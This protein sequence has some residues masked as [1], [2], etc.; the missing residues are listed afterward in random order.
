MQNSGKKLGQYFLFNQKKIRKIV[1]ALDL[2]PGDV[3]IEIGP[4]HG[5]LTREIIKELKSVAANEW[6]FILIEK[7]KKLVLE[8]QRKFQREKGVIVIEGDALKNLES[9]IFR[10]CHQPMVSARQANLKNTNSESVIKNL[11]IVGNIPYY[12]T[13]YL[14][15]ILGE[16]KNKPSLIVITIQ[17]EVA[18]RICSQPPKMNLLAASVQ[19]WAEPKIVERIFRNDFRPQPEVESAVLRLA[20]RI[21][22]PS[23]KEAKIYYPFIRRL[24][25]QPR[26]T[27]GNNLKSM[28]PDCRSRNFGVDLN[29][30]PQNLFLEQIK[31]LAGECEN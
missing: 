19:F 25:Q 11:K 28:V 27:I 10:L 7:D 17:K 12:I 18:E 23:E 9:Q 20:V 6:E 1:A 30:R 22:Q 3:L 4:G 5:E 29:L 8:L 31:K 15:R 21:P 16:L 2:C 24:F 26:K 13:G 14:L